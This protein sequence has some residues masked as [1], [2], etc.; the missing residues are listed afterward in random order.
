MP[1][2]SDTQTWVETHRP[3]L[4]GIER[5]S[6]HASMQS[7]WDDS[8]NGGMILYIIRTEERV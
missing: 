5:L 6:E 1:L 8:T 7:A 4:E 3:C 2:P